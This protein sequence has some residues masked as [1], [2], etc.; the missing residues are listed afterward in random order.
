MCRVLG[1]SRSGFYA[2]QRR[3]PSTRARDDAAL[4]ARIQAIHAASHQTYGAPRVHAALHAEGV[5]TSR[6]RVAR[7][8]RQAEL[9]GIHRRRDRRPAR[10]ARRERPAPDLVE[11]SFTATGPDE[12]WVGDITQIPTAAGPLH[13]AVVIDV[14]S[15]RV[16]GWAMRSRSTAALTVAAVEQAAQYR[17]ASGVIHH[18]DQGAQYTSQA[19]RR[20]CRHGRI[21]VSM[22][23]VGDCY[24]NAL[25][26]SFFATLKCELVRRHR[27]RTRQEARRA[28]FAYI[29]GFYNTRRLHSAIG[30]RSPI[31]YERMHL[32]DP[33]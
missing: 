20:H 3:E 11:R 31:T 14:F 9:V 32:S 33:T 29:D 13:L 17:A 26:E 23:S 16:V 27:W 18:S 2:W 22:G 19:F 5:R 24:D 28:I 1:V 6:K 8:M 15:R 10:R 12:L 30:Y 25:C 4:T 7:L 21:R